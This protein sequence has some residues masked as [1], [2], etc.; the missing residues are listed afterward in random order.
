MSEPTTQNQEPEITEEEAKQH[1]ADARAAL[2]K[3]VKKAKQMFSQNIKLADDRLQFATKRLA[4]TEETRDKV[5]EHKDHPE[6]QFHLYNLEL[7][8]RVYGATKT[9]MEIEKACNQTNLAIVE[10]EEPQENP[11]FAIPAEN[12]QYMEARARIDYHM[13]IFLWRSIIEGVDVVM[14][15]SLDQKAVNSQTDEEETWRQG[16]VAELKAAMAGDRELAVFVGQA[17]SE[18]QETQALIEWAGS[19]LGTVRQLAPDAKKGYLE[20]A[21]WAKLNAKVLY[22]TELTDK[23]QAF[24]TL[25]KHFPVPEPAPLPYE[26]IAWSEKPGTGRLGGTGRLAQQGAGQTGRLNQTGRLP[27]Q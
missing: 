11:V 24:P 23:A 16:N 12:A 6:G 14:R 4:E 15:A 8:C 26:Q 19:S 2:D 1:L 20:D 27:R 17:G 22:L 21:D 10:S 3:E 18:L 7:L 9:M 5:A 13:G 25:A